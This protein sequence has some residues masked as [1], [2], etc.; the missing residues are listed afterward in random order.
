VIVPVKEIASVVAE[1]EILRLTTE[2]NE[3]YTL[4]DRLKDLEGR[5][6][7]ARFVRPGRG[8]LANVEMMRRVSSMPGGTYVVTM[9]SGQQVAV[10]R[11]QGRIL[12][13]H[14]LKL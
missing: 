2:R 5:L 7:P 1:G 12:R 13:E 11:I 14:L 10:S 3:A 8:T 4:S 6:D 9:S